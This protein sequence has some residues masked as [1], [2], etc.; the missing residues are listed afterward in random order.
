MGS[1]RHGQGPGDV[2]GRP[3]GP[4]ARHPGR[5]DRR[6]QRF[7]T[8]VRH[9]PDDHDH[10]A[11]TDRRGDRREHPEADAASS[12]TTASGSPTPS[13]A[14]ARAPSC[15]STGCCSRSG[16]TSRSPRRW[17]SAA[18]A[19]SRSTCSATARS[20]RPRDMWRYSMTAFGEQVIALLDHLDDRRGRRR[21]H[22]AGR[23]HRRSRSPSLAPERCA[24]W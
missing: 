18:T 23:Q 21:R 4:A 11:R 1:A 16:C 24:A 7:P 22:V 14:R 13:T 12:S 2:R 9:E 6:R 10:G 20:D 17:P 5:V 15:S 19:S 3:V 8:R